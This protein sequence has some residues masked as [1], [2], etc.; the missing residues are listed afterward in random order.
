MVGPA[1]EG[2]AGSLDSGLQL[3]GGRL[4]TLDWFAP[5]LPASWTAGCLGVQQGIRRHRGHFTGSG[6]AS[7]PLSGVDGD[8]EGVVGYCFI[9]V[10]LQQWCVSIEIGHWSA[11]YDRL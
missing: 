9:A 3:L 7:T 8:G 10:H 1:G 11:V 5:S 6:E 2:L 4:Y